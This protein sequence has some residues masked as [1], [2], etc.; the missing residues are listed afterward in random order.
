MSV[1]QLCGPVSAAAAAFC[2]IEQ[3]LD[4]EWLWTALHALIK[5]AGPSAHPQRHP[6]MA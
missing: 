1:T 4:V 5:L 6:V 3:T 2:V